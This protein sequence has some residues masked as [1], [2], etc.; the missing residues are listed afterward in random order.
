MDEL[1]KTYLR[2]QLY[3]RLNMPVSVASSMS[4]YRIMSDTKLLNCMCECM[5]T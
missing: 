1:H 2:Q 4:M 3:C 5:Y